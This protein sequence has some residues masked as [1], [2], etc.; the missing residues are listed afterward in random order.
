[1]IVGGDEADWPRERIAFLDVEAGDFYGTGA[2]G[3]EASTSV[4]V[5][6]D[7]DSQSRA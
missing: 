4:L 6:G 2:K 1:M 3:C 5:D 7:W